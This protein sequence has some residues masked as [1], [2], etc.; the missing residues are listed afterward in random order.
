MHQVLAPRGTE[1]HA[2]QSFAL[3]GLGGAGKTQAALNFVF[4]YMDEF[5]A[6][7]WAHADTRGKLLE[8]FAGF[9]VELGLT[10]EGDSNRTGRDALKKWFE[11]ASMPANLRLGVPR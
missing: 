6:V 1:P 9:A 8:G 2:Q 3:C 11:E 4:E 10:N 5:P 7:L